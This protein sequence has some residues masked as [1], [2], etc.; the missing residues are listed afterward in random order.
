M[1]GGDFGS[2]GQRHLGT[3]LQDL[4]PVYLFGTPSML[5]VDG[6]A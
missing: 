4:F 3:H 6:L 2:T 5:G 1:V